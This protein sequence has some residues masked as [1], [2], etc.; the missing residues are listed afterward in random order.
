MNTHRENPFLHAYG[1]PHETVPFNRIELNDY[2][3]A[4]REGMDEEDREIERITDNTEPPTF[5]NTILALENSGALLERVTTVFFNLMSAET[6]DE[7]DAL[8]EKMMPELSE[9]S[10]NISLNPKLFSRIKQVYAQKESLKL[11]AEEKQLLQKTYDGFMRNGADLSDSDKEIYR[12]LSAELSSLTLKFAQNHLKET[13]SFELVLTDKNELEGLPESTVEA[14]RH[15]AEE[16][17]KKDC[18]MFTLQAPSYVPFMKYSAKRGLRKKLY[19][20][21]NTQ[22]THANEYNNTE[23]VKRIVNI[24]M[25]MAQLL[26]FKDFADYVLRKRM[27][28]NSGNVYKL[29]ND[30]LDAYSPAARKEV[31]EVEK[32]ARETEG[33][34]FIL[35]PWDFSY[36]AEKLKDRKYS[37]N[38]EELRPYFELGKVKQGVFGLAT[39]LYGITFKEN[40]EI[41]VYHPDVQAYEV[42]DKDGSYLAVLYA[43]FHPR[44]GKRSGAWMTSY[45]EQW[46]DAE[47]NN[48]RPHVS[49]TTNFTKPTSD[50]PALLT[51]SE[52]TTFLHEFGHALHGIFANTRFKSMSGTNVYWDFVELP[53]QIMENFATEKEFLSTFARH[54]VTG[55]PIPEELI[56]RIIDSSNFNAAYA[57]LRQVSF[58]LLDMA[59]YTRTSPFE[60]DVKAYEKESWT[61]AQTL[62]QPDETCMSVQ[63]GHIMSGGYAAG[64]YSYKWAEVL[65]ADAFSLFQEKG[66]FNSEVAQSFRDC[67]LSKGGTE[68]PMTLYKRFR[69]QGPTIDALLRRNGIKQ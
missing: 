1:T 46:T 61:K 26:G 32:L 52:V 42:Y 51:F 63:F 55:E 22:C 20:A 3:P 29:L 56:R 2:E 39:R 18:W 36:Y 4:I 64:Y 69:G 62:P 37:L 68:H 5:E 24:R 59:W 13:N 49:I 50:R 21:Y 57:C 47:G 60:G 11:T 66:I 33:E 28:E 44:A 16:K 35:M 40:K 25:E 54:Y 53:S 31:E 34:N 41:P 38:D 67:I 23:I 7:M 10:N 58:G 48:S 12:K 19:M 43:D 27:A 8:A 30:L 65:D 45:K 17:G 15:A 9:H 14:A 6:C